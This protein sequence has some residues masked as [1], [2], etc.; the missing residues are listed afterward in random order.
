MKDYELR[1]RAAKMLLAQFQQ[2]NIYTQFA[3]D[4]ASRELVSTV[5]HELTNCETVK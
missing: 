2:Q 4:P 3:D 5:I 1:E